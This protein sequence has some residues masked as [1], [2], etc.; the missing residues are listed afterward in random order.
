M[1]IA[2][3]AMGGDKAPEAIILGCCQSLPLLDDDD[4][5]IL[6][7]SRQVIE[8][9]LR[10]Q[11]VSDPRL[12]IEPAESVIEMHE[13]PVEAVRQKQ[14]SSVVR[15]C[16]LAGRKAENP[17]D[18]VISAG[19]TGAMVSAATMYMRRL[20]GVH[21]P[22]IAAT[23]PS[24]GGR[25]VI[26][27][28]GANPEPRP[29]HLAQYGVM[30][31]TYARGVLGIESPRVALLNIGAEEAKGTKMIRE[32]RA[33]LEAAPGLNYIGYVEG[34]ELFE[35]GADVVVTDGFVGNAMLKMSEGLARGLLDIIFREVIEYDP[36]I[37]S[38]LQPVA[39]ILRKKHDYHEF[40]GAPLL[41]VNGV[42]VICHGSSEPRTIVSAVRNTRD[43]LQAHVNDAIVHR[44]AELGPLLDRASSSEGAE[45][46]RPVQE[47]V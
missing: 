9:A 43:Y 47:A 19:N 38:Q 2:I 8:D 42:C 15:M 1:R 44:L 13:P 10:E 31:E 39:E 6:V 26:C 7:G 40:G 17:V 29:S 41:G 25:F 46:G 14:D 5:L 33:A 4:R 32:V 16:L 20:R 11:G 34:R 24:F 45:Q 35:G 27:D 21:R 36:K 23:V 3:D 30:A 12:E 22:G 37:A 18:A 28:V